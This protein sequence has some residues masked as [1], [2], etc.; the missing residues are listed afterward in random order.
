MKAGWL[1][2]FFISSV[3]VHAE[4]QIKYSSKIINFTGGPSL[5]GHFS[6]LQECE[7]MR[8]S[9]AQA[10]GEYANLMN[11]S[12]C[13]GSASSGGGGGS[14]GGYSGPDAWKYEL[15]GGLLE[16]M[17]RGLMQ[18]ILAPAEDSS[19]NTYEQEKARQEEEQ[20]R[21]KMQAEYQEKLKQ[22]IQTLEQQFAERD[23]EQFSQ[24][25]KTLANKFESRYSA[26]VGKDENVKTLKQLNCAAYQSLAAAKVQIGHFNPKELNSPMEAIRSGSD[27][28]LSSASS[29]PEVP[30]K[31]PEPD[32]P[33]PLQFQ[34]E[35][36]T[37]VLHEA[38]A[39]NTTFFEMKEKIR[40]VDRNISA[41]KSS[42]N[43]LAHQP[44][45]TADEDKDLAEARK[46][47]ED[48][49][50]ERGKIVEEIN[51]NVAE[52]DKK[53]TV[54]SSMRQQYD[55]PKPKEKLPKGGKAK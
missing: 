54:L 55:L 22:Q 21:L 6:T 27:F 12:S 23:K 13:V 44:K 42:V 7:N 39:L 26:T 46:L 47:L 20:K 34:Q 9:S 41:I 36:Y 11:N 35:L 33:E 32:K 30:I 51:S 10:S 1:F 25:T 37:F 5:R 43:T 18:N 38:E 50:E 28:T 15:M 53:L 24:K 17:M 3:L 31:I 48:A 14:S 16:G 2:L 29:C 40:N 4:Y 19:A 52:W 8:H 49:M 45:R